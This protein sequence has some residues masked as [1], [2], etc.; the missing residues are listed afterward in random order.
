M[1]KPHPQVHFAGHIETPH[2]GLP[3]YLVLCG[4]NSWLWH[5]LCWA[6]EAQRL[7][8]LPFSA[9]WLNVILRWCVDRMVG[10]RSLGSPSLAVV[11]WAMR[12]VCSLVSFPGWGW[13]GMLFWES[14]C[15]LLGVCREWDCQCVY[16]LSLPMG[17]VL[18]RVSIALTRHHDQDSSHKDSI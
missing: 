3:L 18:V 7:T 10:C 5:F 12:M 1:A 11:G 15:R 8:R 14:L 4:S 2:S 16:W 17:C 13:Y 9:C 6:K